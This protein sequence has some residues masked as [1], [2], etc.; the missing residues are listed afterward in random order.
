MF[1]WGKTVTVLKAYDEEYKKDAKI[2]ALNRIIPCRTVKDG[3]ATS[4]NR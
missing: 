1:V 4:D 3:S 2:I